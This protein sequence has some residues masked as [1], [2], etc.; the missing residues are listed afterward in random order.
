MTQ[1][2]A[3]Q[4]RMSATKEALALQFAYNLITERAAKHELIRYR[5]VKTMES[6]EIEDAL[7]AVRQAYIRSMQSLEGRKEPQE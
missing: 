6:V 7:K 5:D 1:K 4:K 2:D 3:T